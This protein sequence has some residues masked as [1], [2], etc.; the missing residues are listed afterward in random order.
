LTSCEQENIDVPNIEEV[1]I[2]EYQQEAQS[3]TDVLESFQNMTF[4]KMTVPI[5]GNSLSTPNSDDL[6]ELNGELLVSDMGD[7]IG[8]VSVT[9]ADNSINGVVSFDNEVI[10][11]SRDGQVVEFNPNDMETIL[12][13]SG[14]DKKE[15]Y[16]NTFDVIDDLVERKNSKTSTLLS[17]E[18]Q[19]LSA[20]SAIFNSTPWIAN[21]NYAISSDYFRGCSWWKKAAI[22]A[23]AASIIAFGN[24]ACATICTI[25][26]T[27]TFGALAVPCVWVVGTCSVAAI[28]GGWA[29]KDYLYG[30]FC[31]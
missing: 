19:A 8:K 3:D 21:A 20:Y 6:V 31:G 27:M 14:Y 10:S 30:K 24:I 22:Y 26:T 15:V 12:V 23:A 17:I 5:F 2:S 16:A 18:M 28:S 4:S 9:S 1:N 13:I 7:V 11:Y 25:G 29:A